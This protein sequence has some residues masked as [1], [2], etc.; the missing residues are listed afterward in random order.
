MANRDALILPDLSPAIK[1]GVR[2]GRAGDDADAEPE[3][4]RFVPGRRRSDD[5]GGVQQAALR[6]D[7]SAT[8]GQARGRARGVGGGRSA[9][10][11]EIGARLR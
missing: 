10:L 6:V 4:L 9:A 11:S 8:S 5:G 2:R 3:E 1:R 7:L